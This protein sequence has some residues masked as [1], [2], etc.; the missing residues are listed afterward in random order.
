MRAIEI[1]CSCIIMNEDACLM[2]YGL[3]FLMNHKLLN[4]FM[5]V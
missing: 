2:C 4:L 5:P 3:N 1:N